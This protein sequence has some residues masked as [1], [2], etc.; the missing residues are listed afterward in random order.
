MSSEHSS[1]DDPIGDASGGGRG[2]SG[3]LGEPREWPEEFC[4]ELVLGAR[5]S[6]ERARTSWRRR[7]TA[8]AVGDKAESSNDG[9]A[10][11]GARVDGATAR[12]FPAK[13]SRGR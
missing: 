5:R 2:K 6:Q 4:G 9:E 12:D 8:D 11:A 10:M 7:S 3:I 1:K 13:E